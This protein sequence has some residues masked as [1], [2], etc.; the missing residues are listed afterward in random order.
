MGPRPP[1]C[2]MSWNT[3][4]QPFSF[5][6]ISLYAKRVWHPGENLPSCWS[7]SIQVCRMG[8]TPCGPY[9]T[10]LRCTAAWRHSRRLMGCQMASASSSLIWQHFSPA[11]VHARQLER[12]KRGKIHIWCHSLRIGLPLRVS[13]KA[14]IRPLGLISK[15][16]GSCF[17]A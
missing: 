8:R 16:H 12:E 10:G 7:R 15:N 14:G 1:I 2:H 4:C 11:C 3:S 13:V 17:R 9:R 6:S 5:F